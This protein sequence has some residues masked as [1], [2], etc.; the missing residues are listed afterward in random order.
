MRIN[1]V[2]KCI[3]FLNFGSFPGTIMFVMGFSYDELLKTSKRKKYKE[4][5]AGI[6]DDQFKGLYNQGSWFAMKNT[7]EHSKTKEQKTL[8][9]VCLPFD[10][11]MGKP[12][13][14]CRLAHEV[15]HIV[16]FHLKDILNRNEEFEAEAYTHTHVMYQ[17]LNAMG[18]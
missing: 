11:F 18:L 6:E 9:F 7:I 4:W 2:V 13:D 5:I 17:C 14:Y 16:A 15:H 10:V 3:E 12:Y 1:K 8:Y